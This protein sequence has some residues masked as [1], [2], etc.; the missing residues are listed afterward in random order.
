MEIT[1]L[2]SNQEILEKKIIELQVK[3]EFL[4]TKLQPIITGY[5]SN[6]RPQTP[7]GYVKP[8]YENKHNPGTHGYFIVKVAYDVY[9][10]GLDENSLRDCVKKQLTTIGKAINSSAFA[11]AVNDNIRRGFIKKDSEGFYSYLT[12]N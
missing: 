11:R 7:R 1:F 2:K 3:L 12:P 9:P 10:E 4:A 5:Y 8:T 6:N